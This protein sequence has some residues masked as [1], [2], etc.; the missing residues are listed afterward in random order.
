MNFRCT[1]TSGGGTEYDAG[2]WRLTV[3]NKRLIFQ[4]ID[5]DSV[6][7]PTFSDIRVNRELSEIRDGEKRL[8]G[9]G[10]VLIDHEDGTYTGYPK[11]CGTPYYF[12]PVAVAVKVTERQPT[13]F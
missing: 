5:D 2:L 4:W 13:L 12:E 10:N 8:W 9:Y 3:T 6:D 7:I 11:Q 1:T